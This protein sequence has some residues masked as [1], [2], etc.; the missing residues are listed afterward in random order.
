MSVRHKVE[1]IENG[2]RVEKELNLTRGQ[3]IKLHCKECSGGS[4]SE[5]VKCEIK[6]CPLWPFRCWKQPEGVI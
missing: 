3:A 6:S 4:S 5:A 2:E 1:I